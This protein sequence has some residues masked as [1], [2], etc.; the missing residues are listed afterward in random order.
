MNREILEMETPGA[1]THKRC[2]HCGERI[3]ISAPRV[4]W[5]FYSFCLGCWHDKYPE[6][7]PS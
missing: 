3:P 1:V 7:V 4:E 6:G 5:G 2:R